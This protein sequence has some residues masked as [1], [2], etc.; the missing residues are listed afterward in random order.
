[1]VFNVP[2]IGCTPALLTLASEGAFNSTD[3]LGCL[4]EYNGVVEFANLELEKALDALRQQLE[5][6]TVMVADLYAFMLQAIANP[7]HY[8]NASVPTLHQYHTSKTRNLTQ[9]D[10][11][12][13]RPSNSEESS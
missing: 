6:T 8:G 1:M 10:L 13:N 9:L 11:G 5:D 7:T 3:G 12:I 4:K 2:A